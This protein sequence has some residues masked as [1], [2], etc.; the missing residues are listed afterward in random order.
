MNR[1]QNSR[2]SFLNWL[3]NSK[4]F[5][6]RYIYGL[7]IITITSFLTYASFIKKEWVT[8]FHSYAF[9]FWFGITSYF[10]YFILFF[11]GFW[12]LFS[13]TFKKKNERKFYSFKSRFRFLFWLLLIIVFGLSINLLFDVID[14]NLWLWDKYYDHNFFTRTL[15]WNNNF[16]LDSWIINSDSNVFI[17]GAHLQKSGLLFIIIFDILSITGSNIF[18]FI[19]IFLLFVYAI[20]IMIYKW[21][22]KI[23][24]NKEYRKYHQVIARQKSKFVFEK[25]KSKIDKLINKNSIKPIS[26]KKL[27][28]KLKNIFVDN[29]IFVERFLKISDSYSQ[30]LKEDL[31]WE[32]L[33]NIIFKNNFQNIEEYEIE[34][35]SEQGEISHSN[36]AELD[37]GDST[38]SVSLTKLVEVE[39]INKTQ[40]KIK[41]HRISPFA[42]KD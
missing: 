33:P 32:N 4:V 15:L 19:I 25:I 41:K 5:G 30:V 3:I 1:N 17:S 31:S 27:I 13:N 20:L 7:I 38:W 22:L 24:F 10:I 26:E 35:I 2:N 6:N 37:A 39:K 42:K 28:L 14:N 23:I 18:I 8:T 34:S 12:L 36:D 11:Y 29:L 16:K 21:P 40:Q 9:G